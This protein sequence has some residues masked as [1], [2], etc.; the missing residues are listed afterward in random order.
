MANDDDDDGHHGGGASKNDHQAKATSPT[1]SHQGIDVAATP[2]NTTP[3]RERG[4]KEEK[5]DPGSILSATERPPSFVARAMGIM[6]LKR[7]D[8]TSQV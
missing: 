1:T 6:L 7:Q 8:A 3:A 4:E 2:T 5:K